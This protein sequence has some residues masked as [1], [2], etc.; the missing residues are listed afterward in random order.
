MGREASVYMPQALAPKQL[1]K[2]IHFIPVPHNCIID[3]H[4][5]PESHNSFIDTHTIP[6]H[7]QRQQAGL[8]SGAKR[9]FICPSAAG[10]FTFGRE[11]PVYMPIGGRPFTFGLQTRLLSGAEYIWLPAAS[12]FTFGRG[13][14]MADLPTPTPFGVDL[15]LSAKST[16]ST[17]SSF[18]HNLPLLDIYP[19]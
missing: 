16:P 14:Y 12:R 11:A 3:I 6:T 15:P 2:D 1:V 5:I 13:V 9:P 19:Q 18:G 10:G 4:T 7:A 8:L 17:P